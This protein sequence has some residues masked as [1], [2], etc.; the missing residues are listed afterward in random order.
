MKVNPANTS[1]ILLNEIQQIIY[2]LYLTKE[3]TKKVYSNI[4][5]SLKV[6]YRMDTLSM[7]SKNSKTSDPFRLL[8]NHAAKMNLKS[9][10]K[11]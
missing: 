7:N 4:M 9:F 5:N 2:S 6:K 8:L 1:E 11:S 10:I 3:I